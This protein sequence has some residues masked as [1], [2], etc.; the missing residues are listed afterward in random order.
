M[1]GDVVLTDA[2]AA[3][4]ALIRVLRDGGHRVVGPV[5]RDGAITLDDV[6]GVADLPA[7]WGDEQEPGRYRLSRRDPRALFAHAAP[8]GSPRR[9]TDPPHRPL[10]SADVLDDA[11]GDFEVHVQIRR[12]PEHLAFVGLRPCDVAALGVH[13]RV[14]GERHDPAV[15]AVTCAVP[16]STC[17]CASMGTGPAAAGGH[18]LALTELLD[19]GRHE[20]LV[21]VGSDRGAALLAAVQARTP[22][23]AAAPADRAEAAHIVER[24]ARAQQRRLDPDAARRTLDANLEHERWDD[25]AARC[26]SCANCTLVCPTC[27]C[28]AVED[29]T[30]LDGRRAE[31]VARW[32][33]CFALDHSWVHGAGSVRDDTRS[34]YRQWLTHKLATWW[35]QFGESGCVGCG[36][37]ITWCPAGIDLVAEVAA[38]TP[39]EEVRRADVDH[40]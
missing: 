8:A 5:R 39:A 31:R 6:D 4:D 37:C 3:V 18:D 24:A 23:R 40:R 32:D 28:V 36:R 10:W 16:A 35:D 29:R 2:V 19:G 21:D 30:S 9:F 14:R 15:V 26:L 38:M 11:D 20:L 34:R 25:V 33:S 1:A 13:A 22:W 7:G 12:A 17:F 27:F